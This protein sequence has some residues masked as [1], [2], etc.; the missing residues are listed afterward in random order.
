ME[1]L[2]STALREVLDKVAPAIVAGSVN[3]I[4]LEAIRERSGGRWTRKREQVEAFVLRA[5]SR[6]SQAGDLIVPLNDAEFVLVQPNLGRVAAVGVSANLLRET[7]MFFLGAATPDDLRLFQ[8]TGFQDGALEV[9]AIDPGAAPLN[10]GG[11][12]VAGS[13]PGMVAAPRDSLTFSRPASF[14]LVVGDKT[15]DVTVSP[16]PVW[17]VRTRAVASFLLQPTVAFARPGQAPRHGSMSDLTPGMAADVC[18]HSLR[19]GLD[20][21]ASQDAPVAFHLGV[22]LAAM[23][24]SSSRYRILEALRQLEAPIRRFLILELEQLPEGFPP[25]RLAELASMMA[26]YG[27]AV[28]ARAANETCDITGWRRCGLSGV[29]LDTTHIGAD[30]RGAQV[31]LARFAASAADVARECVAYGLG[32]RS[33]LLAAWSAGFT[34]LAGEAIRGVIERPAAARVLPQDV[35]GRDTAA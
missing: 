33:L 28:L 10:P 17:N 13:D 9:E 27:R 32:S 26:P 6:Q 12:D 16:E 30:D 19:Y 22:P 18:L 15:V 4:S 2:T 29:S 7:L 25:G 35:L 3:I 24:Y 23:T 5:F 14:Q 20:A 21:A 11:P 1:R 34:H 8:V 31:R